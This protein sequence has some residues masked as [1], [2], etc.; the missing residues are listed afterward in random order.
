MASLLN[1]DQTLSLPK[2]MYDRH[3]Y[4]QIVDKAN[5][6]MKEAMWHIVHACRILIYTYLTCK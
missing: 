1:S 6:Y 5:I 4:T 2:Y 3:I